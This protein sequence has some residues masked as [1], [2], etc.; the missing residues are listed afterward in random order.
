ME[1]TIS[2]TRFLRIVAKTERLVIY[3][4]QGNEIETQE[5]KLTHGEELEKE[6]AY[7]RMENAFAY[8]DSKVASSCLQIKVGNTDI[9]IINRH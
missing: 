5:R 4:A 9:S 8:P 1:D 7:L 6:N 3:H 2:S